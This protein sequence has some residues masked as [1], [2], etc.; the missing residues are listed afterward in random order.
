MDGEYMS[1]FKFVDG[2]KPIEF[3]YPYQ[4][5]MISMTEA[6]KNQEHIAYIDLVEHLKNMS[7]LAFGEKDLDLLEKIE[8]VTACFK[9]HI[10]RTSKEKLDSSSIYTIEN[11]NSIYNRNMDLKILCEFRFSG[12]VERICIAALRK[13][14][15]R[16]QIPEAQGVSIFYDP[17]RDVKQV[18]KRVN[19]VLEECEIKPC[20]V[21]L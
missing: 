12:V 6:L 10:D 9:K 13:T 15:F 5:I 4:N 2:S 8:E 21:V 1:A 18:V 11:V 3:T 17:E 19:M 20:E 7:I 14:I 16:D